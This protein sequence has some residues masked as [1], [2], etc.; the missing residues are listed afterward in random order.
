MICTDIE[1]N[2]RDLERF[3]SRVVP[4]KAVPLARWRERLEVLLERDGL[5]PLE[6][7]QLTVIIE[8]II[9]LQ[10][11]TGALRYNA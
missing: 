2:L 4:N 7:Q 10:R 1:D 9:E 5:I 6:R 3:I 8:R 11:E